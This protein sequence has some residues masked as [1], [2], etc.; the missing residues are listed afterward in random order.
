MRAASSPTVNAFRYWGPRNT[1]NATSAGMISA[2]DSQPGI[3]EA[4]V[5]TGPVAP[6]SPLQIT[7]RVESAGVQ[8]TIRAGSYLAY[9]AIP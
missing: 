3:L 5:V 2:T 6:T 8:S 9:R 7:L 1:Q 4:I